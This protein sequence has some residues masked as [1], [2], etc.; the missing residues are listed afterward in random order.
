MVTFALRFAGKQTLRH[1]R[2]GS[3]EVQPIIKLT[4]KTFQARLERI[5]SPLKWVMIR[6]PFDAAKIWGKRGQLKVKGEING[7]AFRT[8]LFPKGNGDHMLLVNKRM[9]RGAGAGPGTVA[10]FRLKPDTE[11]RIVS[12]PVELKRAFAEERS[13]RRWF[14]RLNYSTRNEICK[15]I[16]QVK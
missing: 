8:S 7:F 3:W 2:I 12:V 5:D 4:A 9:Q 15:W 10:Q 6:I 11:E 16:A 14:E 13:L 1:N